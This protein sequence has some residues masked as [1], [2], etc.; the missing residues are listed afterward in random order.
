M[1]VQDILA[2]M[3]GYL[4]QIQKFLLQE[5]VIYIGIALFL[6]FLFFLWLRR[7]YRKKIKALQQ[8]NEFATTQ[9]QEA[10]QAKVVAEAKYQ[11][12]LHQQ[13]QLLEKYKTIA[14]KNEQFNQEIEQ[15]RPYKIRYQTA[16]L[17]LDQAKRQVAHLE[18]HNQ[19][20]AEENGRLSNGLQTVE[21]VG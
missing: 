19:R 7:D 6:V 15:L 2:D 4:N 3:Q 1:R 16:A 5:E 10:A 9:Q 21:T 17:N 14:S 18:E 13:K 20:I 8:Q 11:D 12:I